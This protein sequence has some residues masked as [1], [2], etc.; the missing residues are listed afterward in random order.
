MWHRLDTVCAWLLFG[1]AAMASS[2]LRCIVY[3]TGSVAASPR[4]R[5][6]RLSHAPRFVASTP[7]CLRTLS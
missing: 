3:L 4:N 2:A 1:T 6:W 7:S 5:Q